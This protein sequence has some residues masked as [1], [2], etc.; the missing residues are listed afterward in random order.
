MTE[1]FEIDTSEILRLIDDLKVYEF[2]VLN[3]ASW[4]A[5]RAGAKV[6]RD[7]MK[8]ESPVKTGDLKRSAGISGR[9]GFKTPRKHG[10]IGVNVRLKYIKARSPKTGRKRSNSVQKS[11]VYYAGYVVHGTKFMKARPF[12]DAAFRKS[13]ENIALTVTKTLEQELKNYL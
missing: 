2:K 5:V 7:A 13:K 6:A 3:T 8:S 1:I 9:R 4:R 11:K 12:V 10:K